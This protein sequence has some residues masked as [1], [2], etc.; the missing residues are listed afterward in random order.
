MPLGPVDPETARQLFIQHAL[1]EERS[2]GRFRFLDHNRAVVKEIEELAAKQRRSDWIVGQQ[3][4]FQYYDRQLPPHVFDVRAPEAWL[5]QQRRH[6]PT[7]LCMSR[8]DLLPECRGDDRRCDS[9]PTLNLAKA[10]FPLQY[11]FAPGRTGRSHDDRAQTCHQPDLREQI[12]WLVPGRLEEKITALIRS[13]PKSIRRCLVPAPDT[14]RQAAEQLQFGDGP[15]LPTLAQVLE[16]NQWRT[17]TGRRVSTGSAPVTPGD[18][19]PRR[20]R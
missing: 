10:A 13:L 20:R 15:F 12:D 6:N 14:A 19:S 11:R 9:S 7:A 17:R 4:V 5:K 8:E 16:T 1:V 18:E 3:A 2:A